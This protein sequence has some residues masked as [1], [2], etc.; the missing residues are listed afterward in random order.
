MKKAKVFYYHFDWVNIWFI[1]NTSYFIT[2]VYGSFK[3]PCMLWWWQMQVIWG[4][5]LCSIGLWAW[6]YLLKHRL[7][8]FDDEGITID[9]CAPLKWN[10][11]KN[12]EERIVRCCLKKLKIIVLNPKEGIDYKYNFLQRHNGEF[13]PFSIPLY[14]VVTKEDAKAM[15]KIIATKVKLIKLKS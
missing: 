3:C 12:A 14:D 6:K 7:A 10:D 5:C 2:L 11:I 9:T 4:T 13:T 1:L 15:S 8:V